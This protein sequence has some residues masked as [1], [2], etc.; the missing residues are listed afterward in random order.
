[1][2]ALLLFVLVVSSGTVLAADTKKFEIPGFSLGVTSDPMG[3]EWWMPSTKPLELSRYA[4]TNE[5]VTRPIVVTILRYPSS[6]QAKKAF[7]MSWAGRPAAPKAV[8]SPYWDA[9]HQWQVSL[10]QVDRF[11][12][13]GNY[14]VGVYDLPSDSSTEETDRLLHALA[15]NIAKAEPGGAANRSQPAQPATNS[16]PLPAGSGR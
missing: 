2:G 14:V 7:D 8:N 9:A 4:L 10:Q 3:E 15:D 12:L 16:T 11:L 5:V 13:K 6:Q 1:M